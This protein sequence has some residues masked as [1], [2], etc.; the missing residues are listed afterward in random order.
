MVADRSAGR[1]VHGTHMATKAAVLSQPPHAAGPPLYSRLDPPTG[2]FA[3]DEYQP[4]QLKAM[5]R[6]TFQYLQRKAAKVNRTALMLLALSDRLAF[7]AY[8]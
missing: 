7:H 2:D 1:Q 3:L 4:Q 5:Q 8:F 6:I